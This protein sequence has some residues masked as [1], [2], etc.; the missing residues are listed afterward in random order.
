MF[1]NRNL[2]EVMVVTVDEN[3]NFRLNAVNGLPPAP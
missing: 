1:E 2:R 3:Q